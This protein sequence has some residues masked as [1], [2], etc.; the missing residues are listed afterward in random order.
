V[1]K[2]SLVILATTALLTGAVPSIA[3]WHTAF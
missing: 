1:T 3:D 2:S